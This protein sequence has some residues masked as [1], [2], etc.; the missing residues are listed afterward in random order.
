MFLPNICVPGRRRSHVA[1][2][3]P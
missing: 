2:V 1:R 3:S